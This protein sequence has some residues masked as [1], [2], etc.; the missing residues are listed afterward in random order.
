[1]KK[2]ERESEK[3]RLVILFVEGDTE[4][5]FYKALV[6]QL[7]EKNGGRLGCKIDYKNVK[8]VGNY[9]NR[10]VRIMKNDIIPKNSDCEYV[11]VLCYDTDQ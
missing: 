9:K 4:V 6:S 7:H 2:A 10:A 5:E 1:M 11:A 3:E 8:G